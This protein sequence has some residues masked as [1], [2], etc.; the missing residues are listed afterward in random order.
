MFYPTYPASASYWVIKIA[1][2]KQIIKIIK[3]QKKYPLSMMRSPR[4]LR[5]KYDTVNLQKQNLPLK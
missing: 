3:Y 1:D 2:T 4:K 5:K